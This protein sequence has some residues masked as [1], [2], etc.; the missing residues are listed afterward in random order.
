MEMKQVRWQ[1]VQ[2]LKLNQSNFHIFNVFGAV[3]ADNI[4]TDEGYQLNFLFTIL[5]RKII[6]TPMYILSSRIYVKISICLTVQDS[7]KIG[8]LGN[9]NLI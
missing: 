7:F 5:L 2:H 9:I 6:N 1:C 4:P 8:I 3:A